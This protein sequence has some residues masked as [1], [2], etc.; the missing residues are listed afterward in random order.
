MGLTV[1]DAGI[2]IAALDASDAETVRE[3]AGALLA[4]AG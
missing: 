2:V 1:L 3:M 4:S